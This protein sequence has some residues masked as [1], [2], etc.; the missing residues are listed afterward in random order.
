M[1]KQDVIKV[2]TGQMPMLQFF[3]I[4]CIDLGHAPERVAQLVDA[5]QR[6]QNGDFINNLMHYTLNKAQNRFEIVVLTNPKQPNY[7]QIL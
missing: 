4:Y 3:A 6:T 5:L 1:T 7:F 2:M